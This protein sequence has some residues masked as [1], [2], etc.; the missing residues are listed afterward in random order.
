MSVNAYPTSSAQRLL[1]IAVLASV[2][3]GQFCAA[4]PNIVIFFADDLGYSD[5]G[6]FG[7]E[8]E[9]PHLDALAENG[10]RMTQFYNT[11]RCCPSRASLLTSASR[12]ATWQNRPGIGLTWSASGT[13]GTRLKQ[14]PRF[15]VSTI[16]QAS[17]CISTVIGK[18]SRGAI[19]IGTVSC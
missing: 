10:L 18:S 12:S 11:G 13:P 4:R 14:D 9:T 3:C 19:S 6:C 16:S 2:L 8:I 17:T 15:E 5:I 1:V 7:G